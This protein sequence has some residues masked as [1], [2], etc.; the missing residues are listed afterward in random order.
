R[1]VWERAWP[2]VSVVELAVA[3]G[4]P[5]GA[6]LV[7]VQELL[8]QPREGGGWLALR[9]A[10]SL[11]E[12][13]GVALARRLDQ[14]APAGSKRHAAEKRSAKLVIAGGPTAGKEGLVASVAGGEVARLE[15]LIPNSDRQEHRRVEMGFARCGVG[16]DAAVLVLATPSVPVG[17]RFLWRD[18][19]RGAV[20]VVVAVDAERPDEAGPAL[21]ACREQGLA[22]VV[23]V[24]SGCPRPE[25]V[26]EVGAALALEPDIPIVAIDPGERGACMRAL[27][28]L[29]QVV[30]A[31]GGH[32]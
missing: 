31:R 11:S 26:E 20:G 4:M 29:G 25:R 5:L 14:L 23:A 22:H 30:R 12:P 10:V 17:E 32:S 28:G 8:E 6:V 16:G 9:P 15:T 19:A 27:A 3:V 21:A 2:G 18:V 7:A 1:G 24:T 13:A